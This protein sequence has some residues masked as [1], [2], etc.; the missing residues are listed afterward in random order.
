MPVLDKDPDLGKY[1]VLGGKQLKSCL[2]FLLSNYP[3]PFDS[4]RA[5]LIFPKDKSATAPI[6]IM[7]DE[8]YIHTNALQHSLH[9]AIKMLNISSDEKEIAFRKM[10]NSVG[11]LTLTSNDLLWL[12]E[13][14]RACYW[15]WLNLTQDSMFEYNDYRVSHLKDVLFQINTPHPS[16]SDRLNMLVESFHSIFMPVEDKKHLLIRFKQLWNEFVVKQPSI[17]WVD[18][19][20][21]EMGEFLWRYL[22]KDGELMSALPPYFRQTHTDNESCTSFIAALD[23][24]ALQESNK[25]LFI[26][27]AQQARNQRKYKKNEEKEKRKSINISMSDEARRKLKSMAKQNNCSMGMMAEQLILSAPDS[28]PQNRK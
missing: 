2:Y 12:K 13:D 24:C 17:R 16:E 21:K 19:K 3:V 7:V 22:K 27:R 5:F 10:Y 8:K 15:L 6:G 9:D 18:Q 1:P 25:K 23:F 28:P 4:F 14:K 11:I 20:D 26:Y